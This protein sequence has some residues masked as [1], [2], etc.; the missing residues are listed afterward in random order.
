MGIFWWSK[1]D[2]V[3][4]AKCHASHA[5]RTTKDI[6][7]STD[8]SQPTVNGQTNFH[9]CDLAAQASCSCC[10]FGHITGVEGL[11]FHCANMVLT[12]SDEDMCGWCPCWTDMFWKTETVC[13]GMGGFPTYQGQRWWFSNISRTRFSLIGCFVGTG[14]LFICHPSSLTADGGPFVL[15]NQNGWCFAADLDH[16]EYN[17]HY[18]FQDHLC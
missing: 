6:S 7:R 1:L 8:W 18:S 12:E 17:P 13:R 11:R 5:P 9:P 16:L 15:W 14:V 10:G 3:Q 2:D 4:P